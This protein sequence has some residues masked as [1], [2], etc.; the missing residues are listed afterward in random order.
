MTRNVNFTL[1]ILWVAA[2][3]I[4]VFKICF[5]SGAVS[6]NLRPKGHKRRKR[7]PYIN[8]LKTGAAILTLIPHLNAFF[9]AI[10]LCFFQSHFI[11]A[12]S[13]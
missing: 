13:G 8:A 1:Y 3:G 11:E 5:S 2:R 6:L 12:F 4:A 9:S 7:N 10:T